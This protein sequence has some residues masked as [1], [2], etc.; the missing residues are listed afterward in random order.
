MKLN[1]LEIETDFMVKKIFSLE[2]RSFLDNKLEE[3]K[4]AQLLEEDFIKRNEDGIELGRYSLAEVLADKKEADDRA[5]Q[6]DQKRRLDFKK[7]GPLAEKNIKERMK[8]AEYYEAFFYQNAGGK[9][10]IFP[11]ALIYKT[12]QVDDFNG[13]DFVIETSKEHLGIATDVTLVSNMNELRN[14]LDG[15]THDIDRGVFTE[16][17]YFDTND[18]K[19]KLQVLRAIVAAEYESVVRA[20]K[21]WAHDE[22]D[23]GL[24][25]G[26]KIKALLEIEAEFDACLEY[27]KAIKRDKHESI[28]DKSLINIREILSSYSQGELSHYRSKA[29]EDVSYQAILSWV[30]ALKKT[31]KK[32]IEARDNE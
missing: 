10:G 30:D 22:K 11:D 21:L 32:I 27:A 29:E 1:F 16:V 14:K 26:M 20:L 7:L 24:T 17:K 4:D 25:K 12:A 18:P 9:D 3:M 19:E 5:I 13:T 2:E 31:A 23:P 6:F 28:L 8:T 15:L